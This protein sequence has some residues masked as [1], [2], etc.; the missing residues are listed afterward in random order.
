MIVYVE[1]NFILELVFLQ[2]EH[3]SC[4]GIL[5]LA[6]V[7]KLTLVIPAFSV[8]EARTARIRLAKKRV[9]F[10]E[11][12]TRELRELSRSKPYK[13]ISAETEPLTKALIESI[14]DQKKLLED[15]TSRIL[16]IGEVLSLHASTSEV[17]IRNETTLGLEPADSVVYASIMEDIASRQ[18][19]KCFLNRNSKDFDIPDIENELAKHDCK[20]IPSFKNGLA[21][22]N[23][24]L[25]LA[26]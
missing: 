18:G 1:T 16:S 21:Y 3:T 15:I 6:E 11:R 22:I 19:L 5:S 8:T 17:A 9:E 12:L 2:E 10:H 7:G 20:I 24:V 23:S 25:S 26:P 13:E 14:E 4:E